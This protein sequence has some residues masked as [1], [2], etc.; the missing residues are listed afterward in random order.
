MTRTGYRHLDSIRCYFWTPC[1]IATVQ[2]ILSENALDLIYPDC[3]EVHAS[4]GKFQKDG[5]RMM[6]FLLL[7][8]AP[9]VSPLDCP[10]SEPPINKLTTTQ[11]RSAIHSIM[12]AVT[13]HRNF[14]N[15]LRS[16]TYVRIS[17]E[18]WPGY[19]TNFWKKHKRDSA[20]AHLQYFWI[21]TRKPTARGFLYPRKPI[22]MISLP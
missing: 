21:A 8:E 18:T 2:G 1:C 7:W 14:G 10:T 11:D 6:L 13:C 15:K 9:F 3:Q 12:N 16:Q 22:P 5:Q 20:K 17:I 4:E 19:S